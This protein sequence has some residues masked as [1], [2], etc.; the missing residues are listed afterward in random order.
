MITQLLERSL[1]FTSTPTTHCHDEDLTHKNNFTCVVVVVIVMMSPL[2]LLLLLLLLLSLSSSSSATF[3]G[4]GFCLL[5]LGNNCE[6]W[7]QNVG[8]V[9]RNGDSNRRMAAT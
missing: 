4:L 9:S 6:K 7:R 2:L 5:R 1:N 3:H 8:K